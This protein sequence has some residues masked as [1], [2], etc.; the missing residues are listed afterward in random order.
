MRLAIVV[1]S[2]LSL[3]STAAC[4]INPPAPAP[5]PTPVVIAPAPASAPSTIVVPRTY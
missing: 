2:A 5:S 4:T 3:L 1:V